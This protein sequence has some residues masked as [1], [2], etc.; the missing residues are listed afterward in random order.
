MTTDAAELQPFRAEWEAY[1]PTLGSN[2][3]GGWAVACPRSPLWCDYLADATRRIVGEL[4]FDGLYL[5]VSS[6]SACANHYHG[7]GYRRPDAAEWAPT[8]PVFANRELYKRLYR[9]N[10]GG[11]RDAVLFRHGMPVAAVAGF[12]DVVTQGEDWGR[13]GNDQYD[14]LTPGIFRAKEMRIQYGTPYTWYTFHHYYRREKFGGRV[15]LSAILTYCLPHRVLPTAGHLGMWP[16]WDVVDR[17]W[18]KSEFIPYWSPASPIHIEESGV[19]GTVYVKRDEK[20]ALL[21]VANW[22]AAPRTV[23][24]AIDVE[25]MGL[26]RTR[27]KLTRAIEHPMLQPEDAPDTDRMPNAPLDFRNGRVL[28]ALHGRN[29]EVLLLSQE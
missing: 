15:P 10:K 16:V 8:V 7:C 11:G 13:E 22:N 5:D 3:T 18:P 26:D 27:A 25:A 9:L 19:L 14:R 20:E 28:L 21:V 24:V 2:P 29:L 1:P 6:A 23:D 17:F 4:G 12:V